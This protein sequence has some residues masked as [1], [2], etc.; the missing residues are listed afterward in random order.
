MSSRLLQIND[1][2]MLDFSVPQLC[3]LAELILAEME[4]LFQPSKGNLYSKTQT[5]GICHSIAYNLPKNVKLYAL[6]FYT[7]QCL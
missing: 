5:H 6:K 3:N 1:E 2:V 4:M 7:I